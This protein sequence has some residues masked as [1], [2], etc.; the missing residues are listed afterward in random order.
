MLDIEIKTI[1]D[2]QQRYNTVGDYQTTEAG[3]QLLSVSDM[4][5]WKHEFLIAIHELIESALCKDKGITDEVIDAFDMNYEANRVQTDTTSE[6]GDS[7]DAPY[8]DAHVFATNL[9]KMMATELGVDW[10]EYSQACAELTEK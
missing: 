6:P 3:T 9:E 2:K 1:P 10:E 8:H 4:N 5:N 7:P